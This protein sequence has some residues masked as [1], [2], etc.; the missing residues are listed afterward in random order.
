MLSSSNQST[1]EA[2]KFQEKKN[3]L[4]FWQFFNRMWIKS[5]IMNEKVEKVAFMDEKLQNECEVEK[6]LY[7]INDKL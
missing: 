5:Y 4:K 7:N 3:F 2:T 6:M 1:N